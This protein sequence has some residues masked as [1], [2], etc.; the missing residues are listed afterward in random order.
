MK[1]SYT[2]TRDLRIRAAFIIVVAAAS[3]QS[4]VSPAAAQNPRVFTPSYEGKYPIVNSPGVKLGAY[5]PHG[6]FKDYPGDV[7]EGLFLPWQDVELATLATADTYARARGRSLLI[8][9]E[10]WSWAGDWRLTANE[11]R[12]AILGGRYDSTIASVCTSIGKLKSDTTIRWGQEMETTNGRWSWAG[13]NP[14]D[15]IAAYRRFVDHCRTYAPQA[16][17]MWSPKGEDNLVAYYPGDA[18]ADS[19]GLSV[20]A[21]QQY[22]NDKFGRDRTFSERLKPG[23][24]LV[25]RFNKPI[26]VA[27]L[28]Y[29]G[30]EPFNRNWAGEVTKEFAAFPKLTAVVYFND[31]EVY[32][33]PNPY[34][35]PD[36]RVVGPALAN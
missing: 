7:I 9:V 22:D 25:A 20:F 19:I 14:P 24:D 17:Y 26:V 1:N 21:L 27:E 23:Y 8:T 33:W 31:K 2:A 36:W 35:L 28:G 11:L 4:A 13:W 10:P 29:V 16:T 6:D 3:W 15:Y 18:Y 32:P 12:D 30:E 5:D 34:G